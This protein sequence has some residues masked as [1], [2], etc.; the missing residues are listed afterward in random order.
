VGSEGKD[1][2]T[3]LKRKQNAA[4]FEKTKPISIIIR[5]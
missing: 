2:L 5:F 4:N 3:N 1:I